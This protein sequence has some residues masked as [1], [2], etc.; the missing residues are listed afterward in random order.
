MQ[1]RRK[2][3]KITNK[4]MANRME[5]TARKLP[6]KITKRPRHRKMEQRMQIN[7]RTNRIK[8]DLGQMQTH[9]IKISLLRI[10]RRT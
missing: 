1:E 5:R 2:K 7:K 9:R 10:L 4:I 3:T 8:K 6:N